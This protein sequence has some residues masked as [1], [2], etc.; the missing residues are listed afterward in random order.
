MPYSVEHF[1]ERLL[2]E[3]ERWPAGILADYARLI[4]L[5]IELGPDLRMP[6]WVTPKHDLMI[7]R[8]RMKEVRD[9]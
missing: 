7:A 1:N 4:E 3:I 2:A 5:L 9:G 8:R 6:P